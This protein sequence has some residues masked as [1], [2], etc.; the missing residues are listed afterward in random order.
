LAYNALLVLGGGVL[1]ALSARLA[2]PV[3]FSPVP[4][5][6]QTLAVLVVAALLGRTRGSASVVAYLAAGAS[7]LPVFAG[8]GGP[9]YLIGPTGG[10]LIGFIAA[11]YLVGYLAEAGWTRR[12]LPTVV[13]MLAGSATILGCGAL[14][15]G[16]FGGIDAVAAGVVPFLVGDALKVAV[17][18]VV[19]PVAARTVDRR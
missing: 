16:V 9:A 11:S 15:L 1:I 17:A 14:W 18:T 8:G 10:Y 5:T 13:A 7:G 2:F 3:P 4:I 19:L 12:V 6:L